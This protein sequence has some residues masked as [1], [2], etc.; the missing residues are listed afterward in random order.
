MIAGISSPMISSYYIAEFYIIF[1]NP[2]NRSDM[3]GIEEAE[4]CTSEKV[5]KKIKA[6]YGS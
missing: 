5:K 2:E 1:T 4:M 3:I 6:P